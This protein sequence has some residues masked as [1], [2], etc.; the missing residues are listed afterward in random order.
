MRRIGYK[1]A[2]M[3]GTA[4]RSGLT[5][6]EHCL[7]MALLVVMAIAVWE[8]FGPRSHGAANAINP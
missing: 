2:A 6:V 5:V 4:P 8:A 3:L 1:L 7:I